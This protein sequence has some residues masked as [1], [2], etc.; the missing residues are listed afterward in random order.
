MG[1]LSRGLAVAHTL[2]W[3]R[4]EV[5]FVSA[6]PHAGQIL[7]DRAHLP[8]PVQFSGQ[9]VLLRAWLYQLLTERKITEVYL[10]T[11]PVGLFGE[12]N[13]ADRLELPLYLVARTLNWKAY[14]PLL[15]KQPR[16]KEIFVVERLP[17][18]Q[19]SWLI[20]QSEQVSQLLLHYPVVPLPAT[21]QAEFQALPRPLW[22]IVHSQPQEEVEAL[23]DMARDQ[24]RLEAVAPTFC[25]ITQVP[26]ADPGLIVRNWNAAYRLFPGADR[27][28]T[29]GGFNLMQQTH[30][31]RDQ[32]H[33][34]PFVRRY[35]DQ[36]FRVRQV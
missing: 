4:G 31:F 29:G 33:C 30:A 28:F 21:I 2:G 8:I 11:F 5:L 10:D 7:S 22:L 17:A 34:L 19:H 14:A 9:P 15:Q 16:F 13:E 3:R 24:A 18:E 12:W 35:D 26:V 36:F 23:I 6:S 20:Q 27:I 1:H 32:H 25:V